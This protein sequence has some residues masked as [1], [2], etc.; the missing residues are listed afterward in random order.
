MDIKNDSVSTIMP[1]PTSMIVTSVSNVESITYTNTLKIPKTNKYRFS[2][3]RNYTKTKHIDDI[4]YKDLLSMLI[5]TK[6]RGYDSDMVTYVHNTV[7][8]THLAFSKYLCTDPDLLLMEV[9][10]LIHNSTRQIMFS[11]PFYHYF[12]TLSL[13]TNEQDNTQ[14]PP[15]TLE[16][17]LNLALFWVDLHTYET[18]VLS[19]TIELDTNSTPS[20]S[21][22]IWHHNLNAY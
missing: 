10:T 2:L 21:C 4:S 20:K 15:V 9:S 22:S 5:K 11:I 16:Y 13:Y 12:N 8:N 6:M 1:D 18:Q 17:L 14:C 3:C 7:L 19:N